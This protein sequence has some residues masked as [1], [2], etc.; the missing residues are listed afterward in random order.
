[1]AL[2]SVRRLR[3]FTA[4]ARQRAQCG[5]LEGAAGTVSLLGTRVENSPQILSMVTLPA[6]SQ[7]LEVYTGGEGRQRLTRPKTR[8]RLFPEGV[9]SVLSRLN[10]PDLVRLHDPKR[11]IPEPRPV[12]PSKTLPREN[13]HPFR[14]DQG[15]APDKN[16]FILSKVAVRG[17]EL[18]GRTIGRWSRSPLC[19]VYSLVR[20][21]NAS[22]SSEA[23]SGEFLSPL[24]PSG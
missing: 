5:P 4:S 13:H 10:A 1:M 12:S 22:S 21:M 8:D 6:P 15:P 14:P 18:Y 24:S 9:S 16:V 20:T 7:R 11:H 3:R 23:G 19:A 2:Q 17:M